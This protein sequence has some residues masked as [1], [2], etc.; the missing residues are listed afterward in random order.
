MTKLAAAQS[1]QVRNSDDVARIGA[2]SA[3][4]PIVE[5]PNCYVDYIEPKFRDIAPHIVNDPVKSDR[6]VIEGLVEEVP[7]NMAAVAGKDPATFGPASFSR[8]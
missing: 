4:S 2:M 3:D 8:I 7:L 5:P 1:R 6:Y